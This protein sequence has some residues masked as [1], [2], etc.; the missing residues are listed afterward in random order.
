MWPI[1]T[2]HVV[3]CDPA[4]ARRLVRRA[5]VGRRVP[6]LARRHRSKPSVRRPPIGA[7][8]PDAH[9]SPHPRAPRAPRALAL[10]REARAYC[11]RTPEAFA[12][13][14]AAVDAWLRD[15]RPRR[16]RAAR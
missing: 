15:H 5:P 6:P 16:A 1:E 8:N 10:A 4:G 9:R 13:H 14:L 2:G 11:A 7:C 12:H 3:Q